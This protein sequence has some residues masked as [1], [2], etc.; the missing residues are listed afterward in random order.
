M[1]RSTKSCRLGQNIQISVESL[2]KMNHGLLLS[3]QGEKCHIYRLMQVK[4]NLAI[5]KNLR[6]ILLMKSPVPPPISPVLQKD[7]NFPALLHRFRFAFICKW[8]FLADK[9]CSVT[10]G[11]SMLSKWTSKVLAA[12]G[13]VHDRL[14]LTQEFTYSRCHPPATR[15][16]AYFYSQRSCLEGRTRYE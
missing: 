10:K 11:S 6:C 7:S 12:E 16:N 8:S 1:N 4:D 9:P 3:H 14:C 2:D 15:Y 13:T 5:L